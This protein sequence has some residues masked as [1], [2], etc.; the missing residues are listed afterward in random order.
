MKPSHFVMTIPFAFALV[1]GSACGAKETSSTTS[2]SSTT[3]NAP[4][5]KGSAASGPS[6]TATAA[7]A[8]ATAGGSMEGTTEKTLDL[9]S[10]DVK[11]KVK[12]ATPT[13]WSENN[14]TSGVTYQA[15]GSSMSHI[16]I[17]LSCD[18]SCGDA[19]T[20]GKNIQKQANEEFEFVKGKNHIPQLEPTW[21]VKP[22]DE[23][24]GVWFTKWDA[25][26]AGGKQEEHHVVIEK[27]LPGTD[28]LF[29]CEAEVNEHDS[30]WVDR[31]E[32]ACRAA[33]VQLVK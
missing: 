33:D 20:L 13:G 29:R 28:M 9:S 16:S 31:F 22:K 11:L 5:S 18:G 24:S 19:A 4:A 7:A 23:G 30:P 32:K 10:H 12:I 17:G 8:P 27:L 2:A 3:S 15:S 6:G 14:Y 25:K 1:C 26:E 21:A